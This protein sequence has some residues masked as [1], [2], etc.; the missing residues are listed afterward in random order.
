[1]EEI[2]IINS[3]ICKLIEKAHLVMR[4]KEENGYTVFKEYACLHTLIRG[5]KVNFSFSVPIERN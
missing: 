2:K 4:E 5:K 1:M 3:D